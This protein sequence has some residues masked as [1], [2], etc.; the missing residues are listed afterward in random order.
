MKLGKE[1][2]SIL[3]SFSTINQSILFKPGKFL[4]TVNPSSSLFAKASIQEEITDTFAIYDLPR[5]LSTLSL[6]DAPDLTIEGKKITIS[7]GSKKVYYSA[8]EPSLIITPKS[9]N[10][11]ELPVIASVK[12][13]ANIL[14]NSLKALSVLGL[15]EIAFIGKDGDV[16]IKAFD[17]KNKGGDTYSEII[18]QTDQVFETIISDKNMKVVPNDYDLDI[19]SVGAIVLKSQHLQ[20]TIAGEMNSK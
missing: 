19:T 20:Y 15:P 16:L 7:E 5:F 18:G 13:P 10:L 14:N 1:T 8:T 4:T 12:L 3:K 17:S 9:D 6:F 2:L 11:K